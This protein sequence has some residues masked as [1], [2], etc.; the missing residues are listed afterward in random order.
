MC[1]CFCSVKAAVAAVQCVCQVQGFFG[2]DLFECFPGFGVQYFYDDLTQL[3]IYGKF[4]AAG[5]G[6]GLEGFFY[7]GYVGGWL[8][9]CLFAGCGFF[10]RGYGFDCVGCQRLGS[11]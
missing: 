7:L 11:G 9:V 2:G 4:K 5:T 3:V 6:K 1:L 10:C 8:V